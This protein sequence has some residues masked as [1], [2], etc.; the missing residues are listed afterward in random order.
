MAVGCAVTATC[1]TCRR[2]CACLL[3]MT[4]DKSARK[5]KRTDSI[6]SQLAV[7]LPG[8]H[9]S[10]CLLCSAPSMLYALFGALRPRVPRGLRALTAPARSSTSGSYVMA[11]HVTVDHSDRPGRVLDSADGCSIRSMS[12]GT[13]PSPETLLNQ[14]EPHLQKRVS[15]A[16]LID[17]NS[18]KRCASRVPAACPLRT[19]VLTL[20]VGQA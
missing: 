4:A 16:L 6:R 15:G 9:A 18:G 7:R 3:K 11:G 8:H 20:T 2:W 12:A 13:R 1:T 17:D 14:G 5:P 10:Q 19:L